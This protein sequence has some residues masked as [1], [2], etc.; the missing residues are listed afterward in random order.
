MCCKGDGVI[1]DSVLLPFFS[2]T[3]NTGLFYLCIS[4]VLFGVSDGDGWVVSFC[5]PRRRSL[6]SPLLEM[7]RRGGSNWRRQRLFLFIY[8]CLFIYLFAG[9]RGEAVQGVPSLEPRFC[10]VPILLTTFPP[11]LSGTY[12]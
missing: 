7:P 2:G 9:G 3:R 10:C 11:N 5:A 6:Y 4:F 8:F 1:S 12:P